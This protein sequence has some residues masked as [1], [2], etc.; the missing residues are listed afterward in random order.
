MSVEGSPKR[1]CSPSGVDDLDYFQLLDEA[2]KEE[3]IVKHVVQDPLAEDPMVIYLDNGDVHV[4]N[5]KCCPLEL[6]A[7]KCYVCVHSG[8][9]VAPQQIRD[10]FS[11]G[12]QAGSANPDDKGGTPLGGTWKQK[13][14]I[15]GLSQAAFLMSR[16]ANADEPGELYKKVKPAEDSK[17]EK[18]GARCVDE[19]VD[20]DEVEAKRTRSQKTVGE[21]TE[22]LDHLVVDAQNVMRKLINFE[23]REKKTRRT[24]SDEKLVD[25]EQLFAT[26][27]KKYV[28][29]CLTA[30]VRPNFD[31]IHNLGL[32]AH[33]IA[34]AQRKRA[35]V[36]EG[37]S[38]L[39]LKVTMR[40]QVAALAVKLWKASS[41]T[42]YMKTARRGADSFRPFVSGVLYALKRGIKLPD[43]SPVIPEAPE[44]AAALPALRMT[45]HN[46]AAKALHASS[47]RGLC[48]LHRS[49]ASCSGTEASKLYCDAV[50]Q[51]AQLSHAISTGHYDL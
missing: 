26:A 42:N 17:K 49:I 6:N 34:A 48:T 3:G 27:T 21:T 12:R 51:C 16:T 41:Q 28:R 37:Q 10:D 19:L 15:V 11:T 33:K 20:L 18:R 14:D 46:S 9:V 36:A 29:D 22:Q 1:Q 32:T 5:G 50:L 2:L 23:K 7:D 38:A 35:E 25:P 40:H 39:M 31:T 44:L 30:N 45:Q 47:H 4:C 43:G 8:L 24:K 13:K